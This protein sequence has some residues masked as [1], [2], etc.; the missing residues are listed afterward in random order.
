MTFRSGFIGL[1]GTPNAGKSSFLNLV[2][3]EKISIVTAK[4][5]TTRRRINGI[6]NEDDMQAIFVDAPGLVR[7]S[8]GLNPFLI[9]ELNDVI[10]SSD[11]LLAVLSLDEKNPEQLDEIIK[12]CVD[13]K[14]PWA[15][16][17]N[18]IDLSD[19]AHRLGII[20]EKVKLTGQPYFVGTCSHSEGVPQKEIMEYFKSVLPETG[21][22]LYDSEVYT[23]TSVRDICSEIVREKCFEFLHQEIPYSIAVTVMKFDETEKI[24]HIVFEIIVAKESHKPLVIGKKG[25]KLKEIGSAAR[26]E[27]EKLLDSKVFME[28]HVSYKDSWMKNKRLMGDLGYVVKME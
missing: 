8:S 17:I 24:P 26:K 2:L 21:A 9:D 27:I 4:P 10:Q 22:P 18:K 5:Q 6:V 1:V 23:T 7:S 25:E 20:I 13:S 28:L 14:K 11:A 19:K 3:K 16:F 15:A 12:M